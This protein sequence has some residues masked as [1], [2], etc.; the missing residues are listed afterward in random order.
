MSLFSR[1]ARLI[2]LLTLE[3][4]AV[5]AVA[6]M[7]VGCFIIFYSF[8]TAPQEINGTVDF[9]AF[10]VAGRILN[11]YP[12]GNLYNKDLQRKLYIE[13]APVS[14]PIFK[15]YFAYTPFFALFFMPLALL[16]FSWAFI[17]W[18]L[19]SLG[20]FAAGFWLAWSRTGLPI[21]YRSRSFLIALSFLPFFAWCLL[22]GQTSAFGFF[23]LA[24][25][26]Y[27]DRKS[28][29]SS[30]CALAMLL[31]KPPLLI[32]LVPML[33]VTKRWRT[34]F[35][36]SIT[37][38]ML[39]LISV[40]VIA[41]SGILS[42]LEMLNSFSQAKAGTVTRVD[43]DLFS[44]FFRFVGGV[45]ARWFVLGVAVIVVPLLIAAWVKIPNTAWALAIVWTLILN[46]YVLIYDSTLIILSALLFI[47][48]LWPSGLPR[49]FKLILVALFLVAWPEAEV[50]DKFGMQI[51]T[52]VIA[53]FG[54][55][56]LAV[57]G[58]R[59]R[60]SLATN[61]SHKEPSRTSDIA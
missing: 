39:I 11:E 60:H 25:A 21:K 17:C 56:H 29:F 52:I 16:P 35:G 57:V 34:L 32:L 22:A 33:L 6:T 18:I 14:D 41:P 48:L 44:F 37:A 54:I 3:R 36:F 30:G 15:L 26:I 43:I 24:L 50:A 59:N 28:P 58:R 31:Y 13:T 47:S 4:A 10:Y 53:A 38:A 1:F 45:V 42:Y 23:W 27:L 7:I 5:Y 40:A 2:D 9:P 12:R 61:P 8:A 49:T 19:I 20:L 55:Y 51:M 46:F